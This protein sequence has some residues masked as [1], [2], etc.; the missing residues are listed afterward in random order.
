VTRSFYHFPALNT[1][2]F[3]SCFAT[4]QVACVINQTSW[5]TSG[6]LWVWLSNMSLGPMERLTAMVI[7]RHPEYSID[8]SESFRPENDFSMDDCARVHKDS[9]CDLQEFSWRTRQTVILKQLQRFTRR[10]S[11]CLRDGQKSAQW[12]TTTKIPCLSLS[13]RLSLD[14]PYYPW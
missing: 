9:K 8:E 4:L 13:A 11:R 3:T 12:P 5:R 10:D 6:N 7:E 1:H 14:L 2:S